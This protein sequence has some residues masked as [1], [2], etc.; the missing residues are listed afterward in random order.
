MTDIEAQSLKSTCLLARYWEE[1]RLRTS[2][3]ECPKNWFKAFRISCPFIV[4][5]NVRQ[6]QATRVTTRHPMASL[7]STVILATLQVGF[8]NAQILII[9]KT[10]SLSWT[11]SGARYTIELSSGAER[12]ML[13][14]AHTHRTCFRAIFA[15]W[16]V[17]ALAWVSKF[18]CSKQNKGVLSVS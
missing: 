3:R 11:S 16:H 1:I 18:Q 13:P 15:V 7:S 4:L 6:T 8:C 10:K 9:K 5:L 12:H 17:S 2:S 14:I